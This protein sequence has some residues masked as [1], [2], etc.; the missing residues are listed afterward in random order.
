MKLQSRAMKSSRTRNPP[1]QMTF[2]MT[3]RIKSPNL[4]SQVRFLPSL[5]TG[6]SIGS[7]FSYLLW[8][9]TNESHRKLCE[10]WIV[11]AMPVS[12]SLYSTLPNQKNRNCLSPF[13]FLPRNSLCIYFSWWWYIISISSFYN[14]L[15]CI[16]IES[17][18]SKSCHRFLTDVISCWPLQKNL[19][20][21]PTCFNCRTVLGTTVADE[22]IWW[23]WTRGQSPTWLVISSRL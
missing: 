8:L 11:L 22:V 19:D 21:L 5:G 12:I 4:S 23:C 3:T 16:F 15:I 10:T 6:V 7:E 18:I 17:M 9:W 14:L 20:F 13:Y 2:T 1:Y